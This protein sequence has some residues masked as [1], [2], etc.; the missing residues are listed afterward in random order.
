[1][2]RGR[3]VNLGQ[4]KNKFRQYRESAKDRHKSWNLSFE[5]FVSICEKPCFYCGSL[6][7]KGGSNKW[8]HNGIDRKHNDIG[9]EPENCLPCCSICNHGKGTKGYERFVAY[10]IRVANNRSCLAGMEC[11]EFGAKKE[12][13]AEFELRIYG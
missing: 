6:P 8:A 7:L 3:K 5:Q 4:A 2:E 9:Y 11:P 12:I 13:V 10:L 1:M